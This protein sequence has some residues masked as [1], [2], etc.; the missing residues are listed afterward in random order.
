VYG[1]FHGSLP[2]REIT[3]KS[4]LLK[5]NHTRYRW[6]LLHDTT[7]IGRVTI[8]GMLN[9]VSNFVL[10]ICIRIQIQ[11]TIHSFVRVQNGLIVDDACSTVAAGRRQHACHLS[12]WAEEWGGTTRPKTVTRLGTSHGGPTPFLCPLT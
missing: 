4:S 7:S 6:R 2:R 9:I 1:V 3:D 12:Q 8:L 11:E 5:D 10:I